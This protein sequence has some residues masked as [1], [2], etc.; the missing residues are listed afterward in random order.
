[1]NTMSTIIDGLYTHLQTRGYQARVVPSHHLRDLQQEIEG[2]HSQGTLDETLYQEYLT[3]FVF[4]PPA[5]LPQAASIIVVAAPRPQT[6]VTF[7]WNGTHWPLT[8]PPTYA[9]YDEVPRQVQGSL[10]EWL[11]PHGYRV[12]KIHVPL[13][14]LAVRSGLGMYGRNN[15]CYVQGMGSFLQLVAFLSDLPCPEDN[16]G[17]L[18]MLPRCEKCE[19]C[20]RHCPTQAITRSRFVFHGERCLVFHNERAGQIPFPDWIDPT[21][22]HCLVGCMICQRVCP[23]DRAFWDW[24]E[25]EEFSHDETARLLAGVPLDQHD[26]ATVHKLERLGLIDMLDILPRNL[27]ATLKTG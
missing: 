16:W 5:S 11:A 20:I 24:S 15:I 8:L 7:F 10:E 1:M 25:A 17:D 23:E 9:G 26:P 18:R 14:L 19:A 21:A 4:E 2:R 3:S 13:K 27:G 22:H 12:A 6:R